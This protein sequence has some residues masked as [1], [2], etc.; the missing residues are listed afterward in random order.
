M[1]AGKVTFKEILK[2]NLIFWGFWNLFYGI[3]FARMLH[4]LFIF[5]LFNSLFST[6][7]LFL[8][9]LLL[10]PVCRWLKFEGVPRGVFVLLHLVGALLYSTL[11]LGISGL[12]LYAVFQEMFFKMME[13]YQVAG[14]QFPVGVTFYLMVIGGY[15]SLIYYREIQVKQSQMAEM[16]LLMRDAQL[17]VLKNQLNPHFLF[18]VLN[19]LNAL[20]GQH[21]QE[22]RQVLLNLSQLL[23]MSLNAQKKSMVPL[24]EEIQFVHLYLELEKVRLG[25]RLHY[26][27]K[28]DPGLLE[29]KVPVMLLQPLVENAI[30]HGISRIPSG[31]TIELVISAKGQ[32]IH[33]SLINDTGEILPERTGGKSGSGIGQKNLRERLANLYGEEYDFSVRKDISGKYQVSIEIP[34]VKERKEQ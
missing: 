8:L 5:G 6:I 24:K 22:A 14:W 27:E 29:S 32:H 11:W 10:W 2:Y 3:I 23:R 34:W 16:K 31:G 26:V 19:S 18:N 28:V 25:E 7:P 1:T 20:I 33:L 13:P 15:Y 12:I 4:M 17:T 30:Q 9:S 21:P